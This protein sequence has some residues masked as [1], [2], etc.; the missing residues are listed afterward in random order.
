MECSLF[1]DGVVFGLP[2]RTRQVRI[3]TFIIPR[4]QQIVALT[5]HVCHRLASIEKPF[6][7]NELVTLSAK[8]RDLTANAQL[9]LTVRSTK[10]GMQLAPCFQSEM[11]CYTCLQVWDVSQPDREVIVGGATLRLFNSQKQL[12]SG[13]QKLRL[14]AGQKA[15]GCVATTTPGK[16]SELRW[17]Q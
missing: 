6:R 11:N 17:R 15:D 14:W 16:V 10:S 3:F 4:L 5:Y 13:K 7:W 12:K 1:I 8:Y 9:A 2:T